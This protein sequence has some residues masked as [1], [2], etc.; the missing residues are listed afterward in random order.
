MAKIIPFKA[1]R[2]APDKV[3]LM[4]C[5]NYD[6]YSSTELAAR[7]DFNP[8]SFLHVISPAFTNTHLVEHTKRFTTVGKRFREFQEENH[9]VK[10]QKAVFYIYEIRNLQN[11]FT[12]IVAGCAL[13]DLRS[14]V[15]KKHED[16][17]EFRVEILKDYLKCTNFNTEPVLMVYPENA[18]LNTWI[19]LK[20]YNQPLYD[21][22]TTERDRHLIWRIDTESDIEWLENYFE[23]LPN[24]YIADGHH[25][26][27]ASVRLQNEE[28]TS[29]NFVMS[30]LISE[31]QLQIHEYH[32][33]VSDLNGLTTEQFLR[34]LK[35]VCQVE[36]KGPEFWKPQSHLEWGMYLAGSFYKLVPFKI[37]P[38]D[39]GNPLDTLDAQLI[40]DIILTPLLGIEDFRNDDRLYYYAGDQPFFPLKDKIDQGDYE[41]AFLI[42]P[43]SVQ[44]IKEV[45]DACKVMPPKS[46]YIEPKFRSGLFVHDLSDN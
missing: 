16:T 44:Q 42:H 39:S 18:T 13:D 25:R 31:S 8:F 46:T 33:T 12:G 22:S 15:I 32:R 34:K 17:L 21:F 9:F 6:D 10:E 35:Q 1:L 27:E 11:T 28:S 40:S 20:K 37:P 7:L 14:G 19:H 2:P 38:V 43:I 3:A 41:V 4:S 24:L 36:K 29:S 45:A 23:Q 26:S 30:F 5:R